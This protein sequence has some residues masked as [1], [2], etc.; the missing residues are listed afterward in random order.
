[1]MYPFSRQTCKLTL[2]RSIVGTGPNPSHAHPQTITLQAFSVRVAGVLT[3]MIRM[4]DR[5][6]NGRTRRLFD[7]PFHR[8]NHSICGRPSLVFPT[9]NRTIVELFNHTHVQLTISRSELGDV[10]DPLQARLLRRELALQQIGH[11]LVVS[12][13]FS[14]GVPFLR[15]ARQSRTSR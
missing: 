3:P 9:R 12:A 1:M 7:R 15:H 10:G 8:G 4:Q 11:V 13:R 14:V 6:V 5:R 2:G